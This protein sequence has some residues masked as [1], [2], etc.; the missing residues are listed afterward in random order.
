M[1]V[2]A[3][4]KW[5]LYAQTVSLY[6]SW[7]TWA[8]LPLLVHFLFI[9]EFGQEL[10]VPLCRPPATFA[11]FLARWYGPFLT[12]EEP[13]TFFPSLK[14]LT[15]T[16]RG[17]CSQGCPWCSQPQQ[18]FLPCKHEVQQH[19]PCL[20]SHLC[21]EVI[22]STFQKPSGLPVPCCVP[23][24]ADIGIP[25]IPHADQDP[26][27]VRLLPVVWGMATS[28]PTVLSLYS[29]S[30]NL[31]QTPTA[32]SPWA[33]SWCPSAGQLALPVCPSQSAW[34]NPQST[35]VCHQQLFLRTPLVLSLQG[36]LVAVEAVS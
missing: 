17:H 1:W 2:L 4:V 3:S 13:E 11:C 30:S 32:V 27:S 16:I 34:A 29:C 18:F 9:S 7:V 31:Q 21:Q 19:L 14:I 24:P 10:L 5:L 23:L 28:G 15:S 20:L 22:I 6:R 33:L 25:E 35:P 12:L 26:A 8:L 36:V